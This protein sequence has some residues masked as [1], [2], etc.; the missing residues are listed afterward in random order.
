M[1]SITTSGGPGLF[2]FSDWLCEC[3][4]HGRGGEEDGAQQVRD[5]GSGAATE[6]MDLRRVYEQLAVTPR[7]SQ[8]NRS[9]SDLRI[10]CKLRL[11][12]TKMQRGFQP[13]DGGFLRALALES[14]WRGIWR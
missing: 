14:S 11:R 13:V 1:I 10:N 8:S 4:N 2:K 5:D 9:C 7:G 6:D 12:V 3:N